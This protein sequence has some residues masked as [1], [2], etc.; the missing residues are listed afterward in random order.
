MHYVQIMIVFFF[1]MRFVH[2][3]STLFLSVEKVFINWLL[4][5]EYVGEMCTYCVHSEV[6]AFG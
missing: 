3:I 5:G 4:V 1:E 6:H 2:I